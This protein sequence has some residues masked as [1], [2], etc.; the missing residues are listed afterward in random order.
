MQQKL[1][2][3]ALQNLTPSKYKLAIRRKK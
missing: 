2:L 3:K 1:R